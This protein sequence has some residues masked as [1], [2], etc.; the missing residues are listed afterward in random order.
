[1]LDETIANGQSGHT[2]DHEWL[3]RRHNLTFDPR[4]YGA[5]V[6]GSTDDTQAILDAISDSTDGSFILIP[7][8]VMI[9]SDTIVVPP[10]RTV[11]GYGREKSVL[12]AASGSNLDAQL[13]HQA[14]DSNAGTV[15]Q[16]IDFINFAIDGN[17]ANQ[18]GGAGHGLLLM[19]WHSRIEG[20]AVDDCPGDG[21]R[22]TSENKSGGTISNTMVEGRITGNRVFNCDGAG[23]RSA[24]AVNKA[25]DWFCQNN[26]V[27]SCGGPGIEI[28]NEAG[29][30]II[31]NNHTYNCQDASIRVFGGW[32]TL[33]SGNYIE[34]AILADSSTVYTLQVKLKTGIPSIITNNLIWST[35]G[36]NATCDYRV[37][38]V[39]GSGGTGTYNAIASNNVIDGRGGTTNTEYG[40]FITAGAAG[41]TLNVKLD[42]MVLDVS[43]SRQTGTGTVNVL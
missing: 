41:A 35:D 24:S 31:T 1:M 17:K 14:W 25:T 7:P 16:P 5:T 40:E 26:L 22:L 2:S 37:L 13:V 4:D 3:H 12:K 10:Y 18:S 43:T 39:E 32:G 21:I 6:D 38:S 28:S 33:I 36:S 23:I 11:I 42:N 20:L 15:G 9:H 8:G 19:A 34:D 29:G 30:W 27:G